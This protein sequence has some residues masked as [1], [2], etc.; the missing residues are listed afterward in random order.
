MNLHLENR[1][2][3]LPSN[4]LNLCIECDGESDTF[5]LRTFSMK[6]KAFQEEWIDAPPRKP[7]DGTTAVVIDGS[8]NTRPPSSWQLKLSFS[9]K[10]RH[11]PCAC[12]L[13]SS[14][15]DRIGN[16]G[17]EASST[18]LLAQVLSQ[19]QESTYLGFDFEGQEQSD[20]EPVESVPALIK[21]T[22]GIQQV[23]Q[24]KL[25]FNLTSSNLRNISVT[26]KSSSIWERTSVTETSISGLCQHILD[27]RVAEPK[28]H[29][30]AWPVSIEASNFATHGVAS[31][32]DNDA[33]SLCDNAVASLHDNLAP[34][35]QTHHLEVGEPSS[36][37]NRH[38]DGPSRVCRGVEYRIS[39]IEA[40]QDDAFIESR[41]RSNANEN[42][43]VHY[44][45]LQLAEEVKLVDFDEQVEKLVDKNYHVMVEMSSIANEY[46][47]LPWLKEKAKHEQSQSVIVERGK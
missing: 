28:Q 5:E 31:L 36:A 11:F 18:N 10:G 8:I 39:R 4:S 46:S 2:D 15:S 25:K 40:D 23:V 13:L 17:D 37:R 47:K 43:D 6:E 7:P 33:A 26:E 42:G 21:P 16:E 12:S 45:Q 44:R 1:N 41:E 22:V 20:N 27:S 24:P 14:R 29:S 30:I 9:S 35:K 34:T 38:D 3:E 32:Y 19:S